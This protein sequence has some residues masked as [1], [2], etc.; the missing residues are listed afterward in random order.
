MNKALN[1]LGLARK[2]GNI[3]LGE[4]ACG[5][6]CRGGKARLL[7]LAKDAGDSV[8]HRAEYFVRGGKP[9]MMRVDYT[10]E[11]MGLAWGRNVCPIA[12]VTDVRLALAFVKAVGQDER[13]A[14]VLETLERGAQRV[15]KRQQEEKAHKR[16]LRF[17][18]K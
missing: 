9:P 8:S 16:N 14:S 17:G 2:G 12:A 18:K 11:E 4:E 1:L 13:W 10:K 6:A 5:M 15:E 7:I 3:E